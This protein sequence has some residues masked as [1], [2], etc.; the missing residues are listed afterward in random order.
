MQQQR[1]QQE[2][3][4]QS[5]AKKKKTFGLSLVLVSSARHSEVLSISLNN[6]LFLS[7]VIDSSNSADTTDSYV[8]YTLHLQSHVFPPF[9]F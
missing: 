9:F 3:Y 6:F 4:F 7:L 2:I 5:H 8:S 1:T